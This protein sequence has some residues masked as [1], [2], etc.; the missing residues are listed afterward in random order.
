MI[1]RQFYKFLVSLGPAG[2]IYGVLALGL[3]GG[4]GYLTAV[5]LG[6]SSQEP[7]KTVTINVGTGEPGPPG[8]AGPAGPAGETGPKGEIGPAGPVG[9]AGPAGPKGDTGTGGAENCPTGSTFG[10]MVFNAPG[11]QVSILTCIVD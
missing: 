8:P 7:T 10:K 11:G 9:P 6:T 5:A 1:F 3:A 4:T 2:L